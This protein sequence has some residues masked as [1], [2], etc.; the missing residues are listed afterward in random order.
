MRILCITT[1]KD[2]APYLLEW[3][4]HHRAAGV[5]DFLVYSN[6]CSDGTD[7]LLKALQ[8]AGIVRHIPQEKQSGQSIQW[9]ALKDAWKHPLRKKAD[10]VLVLDVDE[11]VNIRV[12]EHRFEDLIAA[13]SPEADAIVLQWRLFGH[14]GV[15]D[16]HDEPV[17]E[18]FT[19]AI[20]PDAQYPIAASLTKTL[21][22]PTGPFNMLG[23]HRPKQKD[24][25]KARRPIMVD[26]SGK[27]LHQDFAMNPDRISVYGQT[28]ARALA[29]VHHYAIKSAMGFL[30][31]RQRGLPNRRKDIGLNY[32][33]E[34]NFN[35]VEDTSIAPMRAA[36]AEVDVKLRSL[37][38]V[39][40]LQEAAVAWHRAQAQALIKD[41]DT[42]KLLTQIVTAGSSEVVPK[43]LQQSLISWY[44]QA[45]KSSE[46]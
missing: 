35:T 16:F 45:Q 33:V 38:G 24:L 5:T 41:P 25:M 27:F 15:I 9:Q 40:A 42:H 11:F 12:G 3:I 14:N 8:K 23:V 39:S 1:V 19:R 46:N 31:K 10:W 44:H 37:P 2:E 28:P 17:T 34:R 29:D 13:A 20:P 32:W 43:N 6:D 22:K 26:G 21:F 7:A 4:A 18:Q 30:V 36:T